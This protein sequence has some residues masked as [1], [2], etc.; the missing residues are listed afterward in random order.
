[1]NESYTD[2]N[3]SKQIEEHEDIQVRLGI[4]EE[5]KRNYNLSD[6][7]VVCIMLSEILEMIDGIKRGK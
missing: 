5:I 6:I 2:W 7:D 3:L 4:I 1:M